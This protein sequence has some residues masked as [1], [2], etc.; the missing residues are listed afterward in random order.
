MNLTAIA[1][2][3][4]EAT[5]ANASNLQVVVTSH[6]VNTSVFLFYLP[7]TQMLTYGVQTAL[8]RAIFLNLSTT[9]GL[10]YNNQNAS[11]A[12]YA[13][14]YTLGNVTSVTAEAASEAVYAQEPAVARRRRLQQF[15]TTDTSSTSSSAYSTGAGGALAA[16]AAPPVVQ[17]AL[18]VPVSLSGFGNSSTSAAAASAQLDALMSS[19]WLYGI[20]SAALGSTPL[21][22][23]G[24]NTPTTSAVMQVQVTASTPE[25]AAHWSSVLASTTADNTLTTAVSQS[26]GANVTLLPRGNEV[27]LPVDRLANFDSRLKNALEGGVLAGIVIGFLILG[28]LACVAFAIVFIMRR[29]RARKLSKPTVKISTP[30]GV[31][32]H[33]HDYF[34]EPRR[35]EP[36]DDHQAAGGT[37][38]RSPCWWPCAGR[39]ASAGSAKQSPRHAEADDRHAYEADEADEAFAAPPRRAAPPAHADEERGERAAPPSHPCCWERPRADEHP[40]DAQERHRAEKLRRVKEAAPKPRPE[41]KSDALFDDDDDDDDEDFDLEEAPEPAR[42]QKARRAPP[43]Q[44]MQR[45]LRNQAE[46]EE[47]IVWEASS[48]NAP[49]PASK[50]PKE[51]ARRAPPAEEPAP[52]PEMTV[53]EASAPQKALALAPAPATAAKAPPPPPAAA[54]APAPS[55]VALPPPP[56]A[57][58]TREASPAPQPTAVVAARPPSA[59]SSPVASPLAS[60]EASFEHSWEPVG[61][62]PRV[63]PP[64]VGRGSGSGPDDLRSDS[65]ASLHEL[66]SA[67]L[68]RVARERAALKSAEELRMQRRRERKAEAMRRIAA[69][70]AAAPPAQ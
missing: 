2:A 70:A 56:K 62:H 41:L 32:E 5:G 59:V 52:E 6:E 22:S 69:A 4:A 47:V 53:W 21:D 31:D 45:E 68:E 9:P 67:D 63:W 38:P 11:Q 57:V 39:G 16:N 50:P 30:M 7:S 36:L 23:I 60:P 15:S 13:L 48:A 44:V 33:E 8:R 66:V 20:L 24:G 18:Q 3:V 42:P 49:A 1:A 19:P 37:P 12:A 54:K 35:D 26:I 65:G 40:H 51:K 64:A 17:Y 28:L 58:R 25:E 43:T 27:K 14:H 55:A 46:P 29:Q 10:A 34:A 61:L